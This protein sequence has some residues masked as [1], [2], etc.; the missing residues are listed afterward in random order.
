[1]RKKGGKYKTNTTKAE[2][3][4]LY[5]KKEQNNGG[6]SN[7][8]GKGIPAAQSVQQYMSAHFQILHWLTRDP[9]F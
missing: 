5:K 4:L 1:M 2:G 3:V 8:L 9:P 7:R 6:I